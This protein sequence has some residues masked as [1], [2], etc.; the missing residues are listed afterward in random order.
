MRQATEMINEA[1]EKLSRDFEVGVNVLSNQTKTWLKRLDA[2]VARLGLDYGTCRTAARQ[3]KTGDFEAALRTIWG[4]QLEIDTNKSDNGTK[5]VRTYTASD[6]AVFTE[7]IEYKN[8]SFV[9]SITGRYSEIPNPGYSLGTVISVYG[10]GDSH[11][12]EID[13]DKAV[14]NALASRNTA[15]I[16]NILFV[17]C[18]IH[19]KFLSKPMLKLKK[20]L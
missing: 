14:R 15:N 6:Y 2:E 1:S 12:I 5:I 18:D 3:F 13:D 10:K 16:Y 17:G 9:H 4:N 7:K 20:L 8:G 11:N 19:S